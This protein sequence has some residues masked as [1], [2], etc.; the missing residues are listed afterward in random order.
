MFPTGDFH[1][2]AMQ[3]G[4]IHP[5]TP[6]RLIS[7]QWG[8]IAIQDNTQGLLLLL[9]TAE[10]VENEVWLSSS[11]TP[12]F[13]AYTH[14]LKII[15]ISLAFDQNAN[16]VLAFTDYAG[17]SFYYFWN[18]IIP[19]YET[20]ALA[21]DFP[22]VTLDD[23]RQFNVAN[24]DVVLVYAHNNAIRYRLHRDRYSIE[25]TPISGLTGTPVE[26]SIIY[27]VSMASSLQVIIIY[28]KTPS[29]FLATLIMK[30]QIVLQKAPVEVL[31]IT[32]NFD[33]TLAFGDF[34][35]SAAAKITVES[36]TDA[37]PEDMFS[38]TPSFTNT[39]VT[40]TIIGGVA[41]NV[42]RLALSAGTDNN[43]VYVVEGVIYVNDSAGI[44]PP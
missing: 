7:Y 42:Y 23:A 22:K 20:V 29:K 36:G 43:C 44:T 14:T 39:T 3:G 17:N 41:G 11:S 10:V 32:F 40:Q 5:W 18:P 38:G 31:P 8:P 6:N 35:T 30:Q 33:H 21:G 28:G 37:S 24:S 15:D 25:Y 16:I 4:L 9:W 27:H 19:G 26:A 1:D 2:P 13:V 12:A 34:I